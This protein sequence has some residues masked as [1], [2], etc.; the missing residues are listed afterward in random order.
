MVTLTFEFPTQ[1]I[2]DLAI[3][4]ISEHYGYP[5]QVPGE[6]VTDGEG[7]ITVP[8]IENPEPRV[9]FAKR[10]V[11]EMLREI[12]VARATKRKAAETQVAVREALHQTVVS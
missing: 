3:I 7:N 1:A 12:V 9:E 2:E 6:P 10:K 8:Q 5:L 4:E 11:A